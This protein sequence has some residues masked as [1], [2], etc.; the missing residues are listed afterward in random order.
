MNFDKQHALVA[1]EEEVPR[2]CE[3]T[4]G[5]LLYYLA[6]GI[7]LFEHT[8]TRCREVISPGVR[9]DVG[10]FRAE[11]LAISPIHDGIS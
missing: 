3:V 8:H 10:G 7:R 6:R 5:L 9:V 1:K 11:G 2:A 4:Y